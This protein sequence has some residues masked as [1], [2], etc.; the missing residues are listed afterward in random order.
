MGQLLKRL[1]LLS[2]GFISFIGTNAWA[3]NFICTLHFMK[4]N[5]WKAHQITLQ[6]MDVAT[7]K[8]IGD[9]IVLPK[10]QD[11]IEVNIPCTPNQDISFS[12]TFSPPIWSDSNMSYPT[13]HFWQSPAALPPGATNWII[14]LCFAN[15]F[16][17]VPLPLEATA[18]CQC[19]FPQGQNIQVLQPSV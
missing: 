18:N 5:C 2:I 8:K 11:E 3:D 15:D 4:N 19:D 10:G 16:T 17:S 14:S 9:P 6:P 1:L 7:Q 13:S 12:A